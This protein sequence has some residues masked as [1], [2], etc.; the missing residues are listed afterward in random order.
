MKTKDELLL[1]IEELKRKRTYW[2]GKMNDSYSEWKENG[3]NYPRLEE[4]QFDVF[5][6][7]I[8]GIEYVLDMRE[9]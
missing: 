5:D 7:M 8:K 4:T 2:Q 6:G 9:I 3:G 1:K